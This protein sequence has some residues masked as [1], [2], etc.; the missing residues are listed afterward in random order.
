MIMTFHIEFS[1]IYTSVYISP[2]EYRQ[3]MGPILNN[4][5]QEFVRT[6]NPC[7]KMVGYLQSENE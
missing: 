7:L 3:S 4:K 5:V 6:P 2:M 1:Y